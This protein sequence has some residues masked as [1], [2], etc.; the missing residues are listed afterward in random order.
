[1]TDQEK[2]KALVP[3]EVTQPKKKRS[4]N[5]SQVPWKEDPKIIERMGLVWT[6]YQDHVTYVEIKRRIAELVD[7][8]GAPIYGDLHINTFKNDIRRSRS[9]L[10]TEHADMIKDMIVERAAGRR[11]I[12]RRLYEEVEHLQRNRSAEYS[13]GTDKDGDPIYVSDSPSDVARAVAALMK[14]IIRNESEADRVLG[15]RKEQGGGGGGD[16]NRVQVLV[17]DGTKVRVL[18]PGDGGG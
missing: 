4:R 13:R 3:D 7:A 12:T 2:S 6:M 17:V 1:M 16:D 18:G 14:E 9:L 15:V 10:A 11:N 5:A 8:E